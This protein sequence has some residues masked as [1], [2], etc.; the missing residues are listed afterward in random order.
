MF[1]PGET[2]WLKGDVGCPV[3]W[4]EPPP[5]DYGPRLARAVRA[6]KVQRVQWLYRGIPKVSGRISRTIS[7]S[8]PSIL[9]TDGRKRA[10]VVATDGRFGM[11]KSIQRIEIL[12]LLSQ[13]MRM[14]T[15][16][17]ATAERLDWW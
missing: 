16:L 9:V 10:I 17:L 3:S 8:D 13:A 15:A 4:N 5:L 14:I 11:L 1:G 2:G 6:L 7:R 12:R